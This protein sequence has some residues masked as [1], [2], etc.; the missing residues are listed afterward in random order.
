MISFFTIEQKGQT[1]VSECQTPTAHVFESGRRLTIYVPMDPASERVCLVSVLPRK[2]ATWLMKDPGSSNR[3]HVDIEI[4]NA[5]TCI[6]TNETISLDEILDNLGIA[7]ISYDGLGDDED[8]ATRQSAFFENVVERPRK[9]DSLSFGIPVSN[10][11]KSLFVE[12]L[13][14]TKANAGPG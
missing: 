6:F 10:T 7:K 14:Q 12:T 8:D 9:A 11:S 2:L 1:F 3:P 13:D 5:L 4:I